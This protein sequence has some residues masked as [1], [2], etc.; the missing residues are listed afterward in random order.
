[1]NPTA[2]H[3]NYYFTCKRKLWLFSHNIKCEHESDF[4]KIGKIYHEDYDKE[5]IEIDN[6]K[7]DAL[8][9]GKVF[10]LKKKNTAPKAAEFQVLY[11]LY[12]LKNHG[13]NTTGIIKYKENNRL[14]EVMLSEELEKELLEVL[15][16]IELLC[17]EDKPPEAK[18]IRYCKNC[19]YYELCFS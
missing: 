7:I 1:M 9:D 13:T 2:T 14:Q 11:Y 10:E 8:R 4:V 15:K 3:I 5:K 17:R 16:N 18:R 19:S 12:V 6:I